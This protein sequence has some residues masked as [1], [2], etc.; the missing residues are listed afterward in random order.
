MNLNNLNGANDTNILRGNGFDDSV[1]SY[2]LTA[3]LGFRVNL[4]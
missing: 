3:Q 1:E 4:L 2:G